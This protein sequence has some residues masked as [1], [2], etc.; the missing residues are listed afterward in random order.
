MGL[1]VALLVSGSLKNSELGDSLLGAIRRHYT[2]RVYLHT[3]DIKFKLDLP[4]L[5]CSAVFSQRNRAL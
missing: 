4:K 1:D 3:E 2:F 5:Y